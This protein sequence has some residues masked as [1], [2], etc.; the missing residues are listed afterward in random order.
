MAFVLSRLLHEVLLELLILMAS[1]RLIVYNS[2]LIVMVFWFA[3]LE[4]ILA[5][6]Q[7]LQ[8][9]FASFI[10]SVKFR[11]DFPARTSA[12]VN[13]PAVVV[14]ATQPLLDDVLSKVLY[15]SLDAQL[16]YSPVV[17]LTIAQ[18]CQLP[19]GNAH[20]CTLI[21]RG[22]NWAPPVFFCRYTRLSFRLMKTTQTNPDTYDNYYR[23][24]LTLCFPHFQASLPCLTS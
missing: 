12:R 23:E 16:S 24:L 13:P 5:G 21:T 4:M 1:A 6:L 17:H 9:F 7:A 11:H 15:Q 20:G 2:A 14:P 8:R 3:I 18:H 19:R 10:A 22:E